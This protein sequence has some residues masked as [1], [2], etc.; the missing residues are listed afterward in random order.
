M[1]FST[2]SAIT[3]LILAC[4]LT[5]AGVWLFVR[6]QP[7]V[8]LLDVPNERSS[9]DRPVPRG[10]GV[11][12][13]TVVIVLL[14]IC[15]R[16]FG[17]EVDPV[18]IGAAGLI[19]LVG[20]IDD[21][22]SIP[23]LPRL[24]IHFLAASVVVWRFEGYYDAQLLFSG[25]AIEKSVPAVS[26][27]FI[28]WM[29][30]AYNFMDGID[31][32]L[33][34]QA[35]LAGFAWMVLGLLTGSPATA[36]LGGLIAGSCLGFLFFNWHPARVFMGDVGSTFLGFTIACIPLLSNEREGI[37]RDH[38]L[39]LSLCF[40]LLFLFDTIYTR[41]R[42]ILI[43]RLPWL[44]HRE[45]LYQKLVRGGVRHGSVSVYFALAGSVVAFLGILAVSL[46]LNVFTVLLA[47]V[48]ACIGLLIWS[49]KKYIDLN[50]R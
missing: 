30:N 35:F 40:S 33:G 11:A 39:V 24:I 32:I 5:S 46:G 26:V 50:I 3:V 16:V 10:G 8:G 21:L 9:H 25:T 4:L 44:P 45:H 48:T 27:L 13:V 37:V 34:A 29:T 17:V 28:V 41:I 12:G 2:A 31:G 15:L 47:A 20:F 19:A 36:L 43:G 38:G 14:F 18:F 22:R 1:A 6:I 42:L 49:R 23:F 7:F